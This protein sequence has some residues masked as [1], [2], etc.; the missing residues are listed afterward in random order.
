L[1]ALIVSYTSHPGGAE[2]IL[3]DHATAIGDDAIVACPGGWLA[4]ELRARGLRVFPLRERSIELRGRRVAAALGLAA[5]AREV[6]ALV[7]ALRPSTLV[8]WGM[9]A[10]LGCARALARLEVERPRFAFQHVDLLPGAVVARAVR[11]A[12]ARAD[13]V[14]AL[15]DAIAHDLDPGGRLGVR[16]IRPGVD[17]ERFS[18]PATPVTPDAPALFLGALAGWKRPELAVEAARLAGVD[19]VVAGAPL[20]DAGRRLEERLRAAARDEPDAATGEPPAA[21]RPDAATRE[22]PAAAR[23]DAAARRHPR[24]TLAGRLADPA[25]ALRQ[26][27]LLLHTADREPYGMALVEALACGVPVVAPASG[28]PREIV[29]DSCAR[30]FRPGDPRAAAAAIEAAH[31]QRDA[32]SAAARARAE[33]LFDLRDSRRRYG[34]LLGEPSAKAAATAATPPRGEGIA[35]VTVLHDSEQD[36]RALLASL[37]RHLPQAHLIAVDSGSADGGAGAGAARDWRGNSTVVELTENVGFGRATNAGVAAA[38]EPV[39]IVLNPD[40]ELLDSSLA[41]LAAQAAG[42]PHRILAPLVLLPDGSRQDS[43]HAEPAA[44]PE[45]VR[46]AVPPPAGG[47]RPYPFL[48]NEPRR[49]G[50]AVGCCLAARTD[51]LKRLGPFDERAFLYA[52]DLDLGLRAADAEVE[53]W[54]WPQARVLH[55]RAH[56]TAQAFGG[57]PFELLAGRRRSVVEERRGTGARRRDDVLQAA[58]F[59]NRALL[60]ALLRRP[61]TRERR[62]L[63]ALVRTSLRGRSA[64]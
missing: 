18:P 55:K 45:L 57:E 19:L 36:L 5:H 42:H 60:K 2:R 37:D 44:A 43:V 11:A 27:S 52:E 21:A 62:Q 26:A 17:L 23:P 30:L 63:K 46:A 33:R 53:T 49:V 48:A 29:D 38:T 22:P 4:D 28:G 61:S 56:S 12:A 41:E 59:A 47:R 9:R 24:V 6:R 40:V 20:D 64:R 54:F 51:T 14:L 10:G 7:E 8:A 1:P 34:E 39:T 13:L 16:V 15:S 25:A 58:T 35:L 32:L 3:A 50:W 31:Q